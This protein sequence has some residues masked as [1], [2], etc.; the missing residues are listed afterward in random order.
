MVAQQP[1]PQSAETVRKI[2]GHAL[3]DAEEITLLIALIE[4]QNKGGVN[5]K[6]NEAGAG[7]AGMVLR[8]ALIARLVTLIARSY[9]KP[10]DGDLHL[11]VAV[12]L[13]MTKTTRE[14][15]EAGN[16]ADK[17]AKGFALDIPIAARR[18]D[19]GNSRHYPRALDSARGLVMN[20]L[21]A[22][23]GQHSLELSML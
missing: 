23:Q 10:K 16:D 13:L 8:N 21:R 17:L 22:S 1:E 12:N 18:P 5:K 19:A 15:V 2:A 7:N 14:V 4:E 9:A 3:S 6:L 20:A 11:R